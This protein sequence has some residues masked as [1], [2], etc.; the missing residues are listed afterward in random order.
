MVGVQ[1][2]ND[3]NDYGVF[4][5]GMALFLRR[6]KDQDTELTIYSAGGK[7]VKEMA[8]EFVN[9]S[10]FKARGISA[11]V[12]MVPETWIRSN[13]EKLEMF[14][15]FCNEKEPFSNLVKFLDNK[16]VDVQ[17]HRYHAIK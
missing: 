13:Y 2:S 17:V 3:F 15:Y 10:N 7:R 5:S 11:K 1:G 9:V 8:L 16:E 12:I 6:L 4:L 14:S